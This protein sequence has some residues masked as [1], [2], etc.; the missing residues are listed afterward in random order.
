MR[1][2]TFRE[3][4]ANIKDGEVWTK[5]NFVIYKDNHSI[6]FCEEGGE[7]VFKMLDSSTF[8]LQ[9]KEY[10]FEEAFK[11]YLEGKE[12]ENNKYRYKIIDGQDKYYSKV[13]REWS[14][15]QDFNLDEIKGKWYIND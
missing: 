9:R 11:A 3:V 12:I 14:E 2:L 13:Y 10:T 8:T 6:L 7:Y 5:G 15:Y 1:E 4:I